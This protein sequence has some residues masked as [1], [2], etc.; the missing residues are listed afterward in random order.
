ML[1]LEEGALA[2]EVWFLAG[3]LFWLLPTYLF[4]ETSNRNIFLRFFGRFTRMTLLT[5]AGVVL[6]ASLRVLN[7]LTLG[8][9]YGACF[10][11]SW[12]R[13]G[14]SVVEVRERILSRLS[15]AEEW[16]VRKGWKERLRF[17]SQILLSPRGVY[18]LPA[19]GAGLVV[20]LLVAEVRLWW[21]L[22]NLRFAHA[23]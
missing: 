2:S 6:L 3:V 10:L 13:S 21:P 12:M 5:V 22:H 17:R 1:W 19:L 14:V 23:N 16:C 18:M 15:A 4:L 7:G 8:A 11:I 9:L 20:L